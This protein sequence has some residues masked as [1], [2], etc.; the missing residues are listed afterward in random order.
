MVGQKRKF[1]LGF[2]ISFLVKSRT[3]RKTHDFPPPT[4]IGRAKSSAKRS[5]SRKGFLWYLLDA[6]VL[7]QLVGALL[8]C[9]VGS[10]VCGSACGEAAALHADLALLVAPR[11]SIVAVDQ[12]WMNQ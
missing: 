10:V 11:C 3:G 9:F 5:D 2:V 6:L 4:I 12:V 1:L 7:A 8:I